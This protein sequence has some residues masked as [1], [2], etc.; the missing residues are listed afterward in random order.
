[1]VLLSL[2][3][4]LMN[5]N[6]IIIGICFMGECH[7]CTKYLIIDAISTYSMLDFS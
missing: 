2:I 5:V 4:F 1:M 7:M 3:N 6:M